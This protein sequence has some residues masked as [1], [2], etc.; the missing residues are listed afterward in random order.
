M[1]REPLK[2]FIILTIVVCIF[3]I[4]I[5][6]YLIEL[7]TVSE[8]EPTVVNTD[9]YA[10]EKNA[11]HDYIIIDVNGKFS[12]ADRNGNRILSPE[13]DVLSTAEN[14]MYYFKKDTKNG[15]L[16]SDLGLVFETED[17]ISTNVSEEFVIYHIGDKKGFINISTGEKI[18]AQYDMVYDFSEGLAAVQIGNA[19]GFI[20]TK[21]ELVIP[22]EYANNAIYQF[23]SGLCNVMTHSDK[24]EKHR[25]YYINKNGEKAIDDEFDYCMPFSEERAF[26]SKDGVWYIIDIEGKRVGE[27]EFGPYDTMAPTVFKEGHAVVIYEGKYGIVDRDGDFTVNPKYEMI[28]D[29]CDGCA[30]FKQNGLFGYLNVKGSVIIAPRF[31]TL[32]NYKNGYAVYSDDHKFGV[33][34]RGAN[35]IVA[36]EYE[37]IVL[38]DN[39]LIKASKNDGDLLYLTKYGKVIWSGAEE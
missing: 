22:C 1:K 12:F 14:G 34:D 37:N 28:S 35:V 6:A 36:P 16:G 30:V 3:A 27:L 7:S 25:C 18:A 10:T 2:M 20:N 32:G 4:C 13:Y 38:L 9:N 33:V 11:Q 23:K 26:V 15:F 21:G 8:Y 39:G 29:I 17:F 24:E 19:T 31:E 5:A